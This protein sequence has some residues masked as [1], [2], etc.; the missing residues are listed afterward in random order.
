MPQALKLRVATRHS[1]YRYKGRLCGLF[2]FL[3]YKGTRDGVQSQRWGT[4][5]PVMGYKGT[6][7]GV[8]RN[9]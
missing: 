6:S 8:Q 9:Q 7:D 1:C 3:G 4:K 2:F 5:E